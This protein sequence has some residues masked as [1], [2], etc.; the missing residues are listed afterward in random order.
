MFW[1]T[2]TPAALL[3]DCLKLYEDKS[4]KKAEKLCRRILSADFPPPEAW[5][6]L[7][8]ILFMQRRLEEALNA[9]HNADALRP[10]YYEAKINLA[11]VSLE[12]QKYEQAEIYAKQSLKLD[13]ASASAFSIWGNA[14]LELDKIDEAVNALEQARNLDSE[15]PW[16]YNYLSQAYQKKA[17]FSKALDAG[18][19]AV[20]LSGNA[21]EQAVGFGYLLY[22]TAAENV[23]DSVQK[24]ADL[25]L[26]KYPGSK[27]TFHMANAVKNSRGITRAAGEYVRSIF[28]AF[29]A[30]FDEV[31]TSLNY[32]T[33]AHIARI[34]EEIYGTG[35]KRKLRILDAGCG[36]GLC[37]NFL[38]KYA[39]FSSLDGVDVSPKMLENAAQKKLYNHLYC[40]DLDSFF[41][42]RK[43]DYDL[44]V[45]ADVFTYFGA[46]DSLIPALGSGLKK[47]GRLI[48]SISEN[49]VTSED[50]FLHISGRFLHR[51]AYVKSLLEKNDFLLEK[52]EYSTLR[53]EGGQT[54]PGYVAVAVRT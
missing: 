38:K 24:Y 46:L 47:G 13:S 10:D 11:N 18:W 6:I 51:L 28:D 17:E 33:P 37:G 8:N 30:D 48:F 4:Y 45:S 41:D 23:V 27:I 19:M 53:E 9:Y 35:S 12:L 32:Q 1:K 14:C 20:D 54:V 31:L 5:V 40:E 16:I 36:T 21:D 34:L 29:A 3:A 7:G 49:N 15:N 25:W 26:K 2:K 52:A 42:R 22:E 50:Y 44:I 43:G 39:G